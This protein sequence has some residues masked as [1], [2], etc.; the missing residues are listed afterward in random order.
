MSGLSSIFSGIGTAYNT[1]VTAGVTPTTASSLA[2]SLF[3]ST[4]T[5]VKPMLATMVANYT[6]AAVLK[7]VSTKIKEVAGLPTSIP[8][9][10]DVIVAD[11]GNLQSIMPLVNDIET[12]L[13]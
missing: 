11:A 8:P 12:L 13:G 1:L 10:L 6:D 3:G 2:S 7:D 4:A 5:T 9:L